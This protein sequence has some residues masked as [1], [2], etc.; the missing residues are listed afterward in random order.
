MSKTYF[1]IAF[2]AVA[3]IEAEDEFEAGM[4]FK[5]LE[6]GLH[7]IDIDNIKMLDV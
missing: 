7:S 1:Q 6:L 2:T 3:T 5:D 4:K